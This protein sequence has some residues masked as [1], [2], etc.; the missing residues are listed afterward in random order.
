M[1]HS[2]QS[3]RAVLTSR[4]P[5]SWSFTGHIG[6][7]A[8]TMGHIEGDF[9]LRCL[10][11]EL[12]CAGGIQFSIEFEW[13]DTGLAQAGKYPTVWLRLSLRKG[14]EKESE[15]EEGDTQH[16]CHCRHKLGEFLLKPHLKVIQ[17]FWVGL[18]DAVS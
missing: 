18:D 2:P 15:E 16:G 3:S 1:E 14:G 13:E 5:P 4:P 9:R 10:A 12:R 6:E 11:W 8:P 17:S 7:V